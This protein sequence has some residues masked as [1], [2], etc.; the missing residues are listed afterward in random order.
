MEASGVAFNYPHLV[1]RGGT[2]VL[3]QSGQASPDDHVFWWRIVR[4]G[5]IAAESG[6]LCKID[7]E[8]S[9]TYI[10]IMLVADQSIQELNLQCGESDF[11]VGAWR[12][13]V[14]HGHPKDAPAQDR[15]H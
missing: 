8:G 6:Q 3:Y 9:D 2:R 1:W 11:R 15:G 4:T 10:G 7:R 13:A 14:H 12:G 5:K